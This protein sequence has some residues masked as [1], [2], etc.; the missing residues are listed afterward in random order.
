MSAA[1]DAEVRQI[2]SLMPQIRMAH[3]PC[4]LWLM[5]GLS[6]TY[7]DGEAQQVK[8]PMIPPAV[9]IMPRERGKTSWSCPLRVEAVRSEGHAAM[10]LPDLNRGGGGSAS[11]SHPARPPTPRVTPFSR[12]TP[13][14]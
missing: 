6:Q 5:P 13:R 14:Q 10:T 2:R 1:L 3:A 7:H 9:T 8:D 4:P 11:G 12:P